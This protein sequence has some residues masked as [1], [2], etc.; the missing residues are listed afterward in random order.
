LEGL[1]RR[2]PAMPQSVFTDAYAG[3]IARLVELRKAMGISQV[4]LARRLGKSQQFVSAVE[5]RV[6]R[7][8]VIELYALLRAIDADPEKV[9]RD[10][11]RSLPRNVRI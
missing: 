4:E 10:L 3:L 5:R 7:L 6:R 8:D 11:Y 1:V 9:V 2:E